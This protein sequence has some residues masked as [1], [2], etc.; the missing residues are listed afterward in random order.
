MNIIQ[1]EHLYKAFG[2]HVI[3]EDFSMHVEEGE[4]VAIEGKS[5]SGKSTLLNLL[6]LLDK[7]DRGDI[8]LFQEK[9]IKPFSRSAERYLKSKIGY[10]FQNFALLDNESVYYNMMLA[11]EHHKIENKKEKIAKALEQVGLKGYEDKKIYKCSGGEQ[12]RISIAR[13]LIKPCELILADEP[14]GSL[15]KE[16]KEVVFS[17]L[18]KLQ[19]MGKTIVVV[20]HDPDLIKIADRTI[21]IATSRLPE[22]KL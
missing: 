10:L 18:K 8:I 5:G 19:T 4:F 2:D 9:N 22:E 6:G 11:I 7:P 20:S 14:T 3:F 12:Q 16:N 21:D 17:L 13:L 1:V 15:D